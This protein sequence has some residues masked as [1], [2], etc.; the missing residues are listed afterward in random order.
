MWVRNYEG[1]FI[2][3]DIS[4]YCQANELYKDIWKI[5]Y[6]VELENDKIDFNRVIV[7]LI[8]S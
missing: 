2:F 1:K 8:I 5:K 4:T 6:N 3:I 7:R